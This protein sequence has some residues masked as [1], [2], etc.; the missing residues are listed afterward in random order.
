[1]DYELRVVRVFVSDWDR[2]LTFYTET[3]GMKAVFADADMGWAELDTGSAHLALERIDP[4]DGESAEL[5][6]RF[7]GVSL[8]VD[9]ISFAYESLR[10]RGVHFEAPPESQPWGASLAHFRDPDGNVLTLIGP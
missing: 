8:A 4:A 1:M 9:E 7:V 10:S 3:L 5:L 6:G 2:A